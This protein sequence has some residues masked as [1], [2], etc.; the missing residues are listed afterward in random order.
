MAF[1]FPGKLIWCLCF[2]EFTSATRD[3]GRFSFSGF[4]ELANKRWQATLQTGYF[5]SLDTEPS[6]MCG[7]E[8]GS[9]GVY[10]AIINRCAMRGQ[11]K[12]EDYQ[13]DGGSRLLSS[14]ENCY[15]TE[16]RNV[17]FQETARRA[18]TEHS[19]NP[20]APR[21]GRTRPFYLKHFTSIVFYFS[22]TF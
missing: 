11:R 14:R 21:P 9:L 13:P 4:G 1:V 8:E 12:P 3:I 2:S 18:H 22:I 17:P 15:C 20:G 10:W 7:T 16:T 19:R 6:S 5:V